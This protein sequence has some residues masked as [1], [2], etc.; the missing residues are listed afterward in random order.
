[1][2]RV[3]S[4][5]ACVRDRLSLLTTSGRPFVQS[6][7]ARASLT[8]THLT[9]VVEC[10]GAVEDMSES[11]VRDCMEC[12]SEPRAKEWRASLCP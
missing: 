7:I 2:H 12:E 8:G 6:R 1:M 5:R 10:M 4:V 3:R 9:P 11:E